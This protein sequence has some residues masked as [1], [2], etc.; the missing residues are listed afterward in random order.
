MLSLVPLEICGVELDLATGLLRAAL[1]VPDPCDPQ[2]RP[3]G[4]PLPVPLPTAAANEPL[5]YLAPDAVDVLA[6]AAQHDVASPTERQRRVTTS[7][8]QVMQ[9]SG[10]SPRSS[11]SSRPRC[12]EWQ[13]RRLRL[14]H[15]GNAVCGKRLLR[16]P[17]LGVT[18]AFALLR[19]LPMSDQDKNVEILALRHQITVLKR[20]LG[21]TR[22]QLSPGDRTFLA[23]LH[24]LPT[25]K[26]HRFRL[27][28]RPKTVPHWHRSLL[29][30]SHATR[31]QSKHPG[32]PRTIHSIRLP[33]LRLTR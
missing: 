24:R 7:A 20:Q 11:P 2:A 32:R 12:A 25:E 3:V 16:L 28:V 18:N 14:E 1:V 30:H 5:K 10:A 15:R 9:R 33:V 27:L 8:R 6:N 19:L 17:Y 29:A 4:W 31:S 21:T 23:L 22:P 26:L 13:P